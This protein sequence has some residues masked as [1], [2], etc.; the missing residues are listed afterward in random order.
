MKLRSFA[1]ST[2]SCLAASCL[3]AACSSASTGTAQPSRTVA[4]GAY[5]VETFAEGNN[6]RFISLATTARTD[7]ALTVTFERATRT[8]RIEARFGLSKSVA[9][10]SFPEDVDEANQRI[11][12]PLAV[13]FNRAAYAPMPKSKTADRGWSTCANPCFELCE[14]QFHDDVHSAACRFGCTNGCIPR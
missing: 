4:V 3:A 10:E 5:T 6:E 1:L 2:L 12:D 13:G 7:D 8:A 11:A 14:A 9:L